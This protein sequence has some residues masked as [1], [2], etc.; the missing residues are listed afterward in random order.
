MHTTTF[1]KENNKVINQDHFRQLMNGLPDGYYHVTIQ[2]I[3]NNTIEKSRKIYFAIVDVVV[4]ITG[5]TKQEVHEEVK[6]ALNVETT[7]DFEIEDW[8]EFINQVK[9]FYYKNLDIIL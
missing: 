2:N 4:K 9:D 3:T 1:T 5:L 8:T 7:Q 6:E